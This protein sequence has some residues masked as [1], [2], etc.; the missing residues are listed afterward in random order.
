MFNRFADNSIIEL[1]ANKV[2]FIGPNNLNINQNVIL[3]TPT[4]CTVD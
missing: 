2:S 4:G 1:D 3:L